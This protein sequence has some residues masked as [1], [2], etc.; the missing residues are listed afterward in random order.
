MKI[1]KTLIRFDLSDS[2]LSYTYDIIEGDLD[3][4]IFDL[5]NTGGHELMKELKSELYENW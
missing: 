3:D 5:V 1:G 2:L 4:R